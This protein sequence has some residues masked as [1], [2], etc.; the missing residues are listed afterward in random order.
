MKQKDDYEKNKRL[1]RKEKNNSVLHHDM[2][3]LEITFIFSKC[4][5]Q[6]CT[7]TLGEWGDRKYGGGGEK[8]IN[9]SLSQ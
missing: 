1:Y 2:A 9:A 5:L 6:I 4:K 3:Y 8:E 7:I